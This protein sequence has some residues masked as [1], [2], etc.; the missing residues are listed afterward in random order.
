MAITTET[1]PITAALHAAQVS[2]AHFNNWLHRGLVVGAEGQIEGGGVRGRR[3]RL[4]G[5]AVMQLAVG[6]AL[7]EAGL[8]ASTALAAAVDF[9]HLGG[10][11]PFGRG[12]TAFRLPGLP[13]ADDALDTMFAV[14]GAR[15][16]AFRPGYGGKDSAAILRDKLAPPGAPFPAVALVNAGEL[17]ANVCTRLGT[18]FRDELAEAY[19]SSEEGAA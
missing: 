13:F 2:R 5:R 8:S 11:E 10:E 17:F 1:F 9:A 19:G 15:T 4:S 16:V 14:A 12:F 7:T 3:H 6:Q 18:D